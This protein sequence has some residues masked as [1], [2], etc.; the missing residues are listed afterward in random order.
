MG[1]LIIVGDVAYESIIE[2]KSKVSRI[3][4]SGY[5]C[6]IGAASV[7]DSDYILF[8]CVGEDFDYSEL[9]RYNINSI[10]IKAF[11]GMMTG[12]FITHVKENGQRIFQSDEGASKFT[13]IDTSLLCDTGIVFLA[14]TNP[15]KQLQIIEKLDGFQGVIACDVF[16]GYCNE[17]RDEI[18]MIFSKCG[19]IFMNDLEK[20][21]LGYMPDDRKMSVIKYGSK[22]AVLWADGKAL[23]VNAPI[24][25]VVNTVGAGDILAGSFLSCLLNGFFPEEALKQ[26]VLTAS[27]SVCYEEKESLLGENYGA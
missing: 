17:Y 13:Y 24:A 8:S 2:K 3:G 18:N 1:K 10:G 12:K 16:E 21:I 6:A 11:S 22:G 25:N 4:G 14:G 9:E 19:I 7:K 26:G 23:S 5:Y 27:R 20:D 15:R